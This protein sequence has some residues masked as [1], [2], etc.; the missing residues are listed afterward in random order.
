MGLLA[1]IEAALRLFG[2]IKELRVSEEEKELLKSAR[3]AKDRMK[4]VFAQMP[5]D[6][7]SSPYI[8]A[9][10]KHFSFDDPRTTAKYRQAFATLI[11]RGWVEHQGG[12]IFLLTADGWDGAD[13]LK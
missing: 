4:G 8:Q 11:K 1:E 2:T 7:T 10:D 9:G 5:G 3:D 13:S 12:I 6:M